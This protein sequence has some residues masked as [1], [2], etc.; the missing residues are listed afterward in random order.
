MNRLIVILL[1]ILFASV[2]ECCAQ[3]ALRQLEHIAGSS[4]EAT[5]A[6]NAGEARA[7]A[8]DG[9]DHGG[10]GN[11]VW[12]ANRREAWNDRREARNR[13]RQQRREARANRRRYHLRDYQPRW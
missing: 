13:I 3:N 8:A 2:A 11:A 9:W 1:A 6:S 4:A 5:R 7:R 10:P 12:K